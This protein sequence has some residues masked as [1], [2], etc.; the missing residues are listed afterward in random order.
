[1]NKQRGF[2]LIELVVVIIILGVLAA[3]AMPRFVNMSVEAKNAAAKGVAG[4]ISSATSI[5]Y[6]AKQAGNA[7][8]LTINANAVCTTAVLTPYVSGVTLVN[9]GA[10]GDNQFNVGVATGGS[11]DCSGSAT[12]AQCAITA[13]G[14]GVA[15]APASVFCAR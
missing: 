12:V 6:A 10:T 2:T 15:E 11:G 8:G 1:M 13:S 3:V 4:A 9:S 14:T 5:N 7:A